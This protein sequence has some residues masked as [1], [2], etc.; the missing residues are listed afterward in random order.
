MTVCGFG[1]MC[2]ASWLSTRCCKWQTL[3]GCEI[4]PWA[5]LGEHRREG[6]VSA[7]LDCVVKRPLRDVLVLVANGWGGRLHG[8]A[9]V[10]DQAQ[11]CHLGGN[12]LFQS[13]WLFFTPLLCLAAL[14]LLSLSGVIFSNDDACY[15]LCLLG[16]VNLLF[17]VHDACRS[18]PPRLITQPCPSTCSWISLLNTVK[19][20]QKHWGYMAASQVDGPLHVTCVKVPNKDVNYWPPYYV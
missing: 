19:T 9:Y 7:T 16:L 6:S 14:T 2:F 5:R 10:S 1:C 3:W 13:K 4:F 11:F 17:L 8:C 12:C 18:M 20:L 15:A